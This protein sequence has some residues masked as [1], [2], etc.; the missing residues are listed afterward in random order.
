M[1]MDEKIIAVVGDYN[2]THELLE[3]TLKAADT[4]VYMFVGQTGLFRS[5]RSR[6]FD[7]AI[8][9]MADEGVRA[10]STIEKIRSR[11]SAVRVVAVLAE[12]VARSTDEFLAMGF[13]AVLREPFGYGELIATVASIIAPNELHKDK[14]S[15][16]AAP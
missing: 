6:R 16:Y 13:D 2:G 9:R 15:G 5:A 8:V 1:V 3:K 7:L 4:R 11:G 10:V 14:G 12:D